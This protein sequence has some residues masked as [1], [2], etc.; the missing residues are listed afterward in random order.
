[1]KGVL[2]L[3][4]A[5]CDFYFSICCFFIAKL[6]EDV[7]GMKKKPRKTPKNITLFVKK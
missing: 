5:R 6:T 1:M 2:P 7:E 4:A 3:L